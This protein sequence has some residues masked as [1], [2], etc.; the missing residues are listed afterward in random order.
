[1]RHKI[2]LASTLFLLAC[3]TPQAAAQQKDP[4]TRDER[5]YYFFDAPNVDTSPRTLSRVFES[6]AWAFV[7]YALPPTTVSDSFRE[8]LQSAEKT[9]VDKQIGSSP[10]AGAATSSVSKTGLT[11]LLGMAFESG[12]LTQT[13]EQNVVTLRANADGFVRFLSN[14]EIFS[15]CN[16]KDSTCNAPGPLKDLELSASFNVSEDGA[17]ALSGTSV[18]GVPGTFSGVLNRRQFASA[19]AR[20]AFQNARD[21]RSKEYRDKWLEWFQ[22]NRSALS[23]A[24]Q[25]LLVFVDKLQKEALATSA[26]NAKGEV[27]K[28]AA[29]GEIDVYTQWQTDTLTEL[30]KASTRPVKEVFQERLD[31]LLEQLRMVDPQFDDNLKN[32]AD[33]Y[34]RYFALRRDLSSTLILDPALTAEY[35]YSEPTLQPQL[36]T[37]KIAFAFSPK[38]APKTANSGTI[39]FNAGLDFYRKPQPTGGGQN[40]SRWKD[41]QVAVQFDRPLGA[42]ASPAQFSLGAYYQYQRNPSIIQIPEG[43]TVLP[44]TS[45]PLPPNTSQILTEKGSIYAVH[46][47]LT[48]QKPGSGIKIPFGLSWSNRTELVQGNEIR[49]HVGF[50]FDTSPLFLLNALK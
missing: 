14:Q 37:V 10:N 4:R 5:L 21:T 20:Y 36:H 12:A 49:G 11:A 40:T 26:K 34:V 48:L 27:L 29:G 16:P 39:T 18:G 2:Y 28:T 31:V 32:L 24:G 9:R 47:T 50:T 25:S 3:W 8:F 35:T 41:A 19:T 44:G 42:A 43:A 38:G 45:I 22:Q 23:S 13:F 17:K 1:M 33:A 6:S 15:A 7:Y 46:A 30:N